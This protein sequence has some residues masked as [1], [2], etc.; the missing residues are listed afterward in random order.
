MRWAA[1]VAAVAA[2]GGCDLAPRYDPPRYVLP[3]SWRGEGP[4]TV[5]NPRDSLPRGPWWERFNDPLLNQLQHRLV[6]ENPGL[7][8]MQ[9]QYV[10]ARAV[11]AQARSGLYPQLSTN[12]QL[13]E[14][15][16]S[17][18]RLFRNPRST[19]PL[20][21]PSNIIQAD[22]T[23][24]PDFWQ[25]IR[26]TERQ[27]ARLAQ[28]TAALVANARLSLQAELAS[29]YIALRGLDGQAAIY[30][31]AVADYEKSVR[32]T[33]LRLRGDIG[34]A[35][36]V[37][38]AESQLASTQVAQAA[39]LA[40]RTVL[41]HGIA[42][43]VGA[44][45]ST[46]SIP[47]DEKSAIANPALPAGVPSQLLERRPDIA[48]AERQM[49]AA[50]AAIGI[51]RAAFYPR[52]TISATAGF[53]DTGFNLA[54]LPNS[55]WA[56]GANALLP[57]FEGGLR[58]AAL[59]RS[60]AQFAQTRD[61]YR[62]TVLGAFGEVEDALTLNASL[63]V[64][65]AAQKRAV[66]SANRARDL[67]QQLYIGGLINYLDVVVAQETALLAATGGIQLNTGG[68]QSTVSLIRALGGGWSAEDLPTEAGTVP[69]GPLDVPGPGDGARPD[70]T[71]AGGAEA[72]RPPG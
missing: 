31:G 64:Q 29:N 69:F 35:L 63:R 13:S 49:A 3:D 19:T 46:F 8:A 32:I 20:T 15:K 22:A 66:A 11:V 43:L 48:S 18:N 52:I 61:N 10:Q 72:S 4:F 39:N 26:N 14:N 54:S 27:A 34:S 70:G 23:W 40:N 9:Q 24:E 6:A 41:E 58:R 50:N 1:A 21:E 17:K 60:W 68:M 5:A 53:Q 33:R 71:G 12:F 45:P 28:S 55:L 51:T 25:R 44:N 62:A 30:R 47:V 7:D 36:D 2:L 38:R 16:E 37:A 42:V 57:L 59:L 67:T 65:G 56:I